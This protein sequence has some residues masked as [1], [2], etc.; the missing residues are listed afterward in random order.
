MFTRTQE[1]QTR[2]KRFG[3]NLLFSARPEDD[4]AWIVAQYHGKDRIE[5]DFKL[6]K[7]P[8]LVR[9]SP[10]R[11]WTDTKIRAYGFCCIMALL[12]LRVMYREAANAGIHMSPALIK[13]GNRSAG[14][15]LISFVAQASRLHSG[16]KQARS[17]PYNLVP[18]MQ[19]RRLRY[20]HA[21]P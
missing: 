14:K 21:I 10:C 13:Q 8:E 11:H 17:A 16:G 1:A 7:D 3:K 4:P 2:K 6:L 9:W 18:A 12:L 5:D 20:K 19:A 15:N